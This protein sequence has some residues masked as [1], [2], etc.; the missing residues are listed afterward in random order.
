M[1]E[2]VEA[3]IASFCLHNSDVSY[4]I[5]NRIHHLLKSTSQ[6]NNL[7][8]GECNQ[9]WINNCVL[10]HVQPDLLLSDVQSVLQQ[11]L[12]AG[13]TTGTIRLLLLSNRLSFRYDTL[14][15]QAAYPI[16]D[17]LISLGQAQSAMNHVLRY[18]HLIVNPEEA[19]SIAFLMA[20]AEEGNHGLRLMDLLEENCIEWLSHSNQIELNEYCLLYTSPS[21]RDATLSRMPSSA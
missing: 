3:R 5:L 21:P 6:D 2:V 12:K 4:C 14:F 7:A 10:L 19:I 1:D 16:A 15:A 20:R 18:G 17:A 11:A 9:E 13:E 8:I